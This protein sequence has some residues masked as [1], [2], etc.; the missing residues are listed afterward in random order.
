MANRAT[1][2]FNLPF[3]FCVK[4]PEQN[5]SGAGV[6]LS[7]LCLRI[8]MKHLLLQIYIGYEDIVGNCGMTS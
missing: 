5:F 1:S 2:Q 3:C 4:K 8:L 7:M 6:L